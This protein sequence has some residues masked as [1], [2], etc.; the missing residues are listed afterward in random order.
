MQ[1]KNKHLLAGKKIFIFNQRIAQAHTR[2][3]DWREA[4]PDAIIPALPRCIPQQV[5]ARV[6]G[7]GGYGVKCG[8]F[9][10]NY[11]VGNVAEGTT[12]NSCAQ[13]RVLSI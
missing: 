10:T 7:I 5:I 8:C 6:A 4:V 9:K 13:K 1:S 11:S 2:D 3:T 12:V